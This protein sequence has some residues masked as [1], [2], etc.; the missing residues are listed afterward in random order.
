MERKRGRAPTRSKGGLGRG[1]AVLDGPPPQKNKNN[2]KKQHWEI[3]DL[4]TNAVLLAGRT[5]W[6]LLLSEV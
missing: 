5:K 3:L 1:G 2:E 4:V 6:I